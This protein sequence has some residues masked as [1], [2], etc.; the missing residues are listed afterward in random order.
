MLSFFIHRF[1]VLGIHFAQKQKSY[2]EKA[3]WAEKWLLQWTPEAEIEIVEA[4]LQGETVE[5]A[6]AFSFK[7]KLEKAIEKFLKEY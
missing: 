5:V 7:E 1:C 2:Q 4:A 3:T 6:V